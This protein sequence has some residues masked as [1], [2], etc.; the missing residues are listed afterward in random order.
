MMHDAKNNTMI[1]ALSWGLVVAWA[2][3]IFVVSAKPGHDFEIGQ[4]IVA[5][6]KN[7][8]AGLLSS[9]TGRPV[10]PSPIGHFF[11]YL[12][13]GGLLANALRFH[14]KSTGKIVAGAL[15]IAAAYAATDE[16]HQYFVPSRA[17][18][19]ADWLVDIAAA[20]IAACVVALA[21]RTLRHR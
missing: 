18:D 9:L 7:W 17:C 12:V 1:K 20:G 10:D 11:E 13:F 21:A 4:G 15:G 16:F 2:I 14:V 6:L 8:L 3:L 5:V 19:P